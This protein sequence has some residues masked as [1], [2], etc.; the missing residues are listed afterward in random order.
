MTFVLL[1][2]ECVARFAIFAGVNF[3]IHRQT[4]SIADFVIAVRL[5]IFNVEFRPIKILNRIRDY[6]DGRIV[7]W[8]H[9]LR[10]LIMTPVSVKPDSVDC[11]I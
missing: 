5:I 8:N 10:Q 9:T 4:Y 7:S 1:N 2:I 3:D 11:R 6:F